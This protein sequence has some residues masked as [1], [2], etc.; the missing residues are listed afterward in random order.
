MEFRISE[1]EV[2]YGE[3]V[4]VTFNLCVGMLEVFNLLLSSESKN[5]ELRV[6]EHVYRPVGPTR[7][8]FVIHLWTSKDA[9]TTAL[10]TRP[11]YG[12]CAPGFPVHTRWVV[13]GTSITPKENDLEGLLVCEKGTS[14][15]PRNLNFSIL[16]YSRVL[17]IHSLGDWLCNS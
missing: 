6:C 15:Q 1:F 14:A 8:V 17:H 5:A 7:I 11:Q 12:P 2:Q 10:G 13:F 4:C 16:F 3:F 9:K